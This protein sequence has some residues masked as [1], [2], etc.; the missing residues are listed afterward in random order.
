MER[1]RI[2]LNLV[3]WTRR[4]GGV[5]T[6]AR[7]LIPE[8]LAAEPGTRV[9]AFV[10]RELD[11]RDRNAPWAGDVEWVTL[12]AT[13]THGPPWRSLLSLRAQWLAVPRLARQR[14]LDV[15]HGLAGIAPLAAPA[16]ATVVTLHDLIWL[17][18]PD[19]MNRRDTLA[20][21]VTAIPSARMVDRVITGSGVARD[22]LVHTL[23]LDGARIDVVPHGVRATERPA[24]P[25]AELRTRLDLGEAPVVLCVSQKRTHKN[26][27]RLIQAVPGLGDAVL[28]LPGAPTPHE[29]DL[30]R[31]AEELGING[32]VR[33]LDWVSDEDL[34]G[35]YKTASSFVLPSF[36]EGFGLPVL[37]AM[38]RGVPV[39][40]SS[41]SSL[42]EVA[43]DA[44]LFFNPSD[45]REMQAAI[46]RLLEDSALA[47]QL[48][49]RGRERAARFTWRRTAEATLASYRRAISRRR[50][51]SFDRRA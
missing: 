14:G 46:R 49:Q 51:L 16:V 9:T 36:E 44:A 24:T 41:A 6:Y 3:F 29:A 21:K 18:H 1:L 33:F 45:I 34:E 50:L 38:A 26:L 19:S 4:A 47:A 17:R 42:P 43:G 37:E 5:G 20:M 7:E 48:Q 13:V 22:D 12:P 23:G 28:V 39:C 32:Q 10:S 30:R 31:L 2:G 35:L 15:V 27:S 40:C 11:E 8:L 25:E